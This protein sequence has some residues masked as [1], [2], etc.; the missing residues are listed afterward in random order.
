M[1][2]S[3]RLNPRSAHNLVEMGRGCAEPLDNEGLVLLFD[4]KNVQHAD[5]GDVRSADALGRLTRSQHRALEELQRRYAD[6]QT[7]NER[8]KEQVD[9]VRLGFTHISTHVSIFCSCN[10]AWNAVSGERGSRQWWNPSRARSGLR[11]RRRKAP[12]ASDSSP[13]PQT[14]PKG[15]RNATK[16]LRR[17][18]RT[19]CS[20]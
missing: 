16:C 2:L 7:E 9:L 1:S 15:R 17:G 18:R 14:R 12:S 5:F 20:A 19:I 11:R 8:L 13:T 10:G 6:Q 3:A 4:H